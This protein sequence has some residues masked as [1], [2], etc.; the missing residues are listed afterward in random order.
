MFCNSILNTARRAVIHQTSGSTKPGISRRILGSQRQCVTSNS[1]RGST[2]YCRRGFQSRSPHWLFQEI[3]YRERYADLHDDAFE[4]ADAANGYDHFLRHGSREGRLGHLLFDPALYQSGL[5]ASERVNVDAIGPYQH[6]LRQIGNGRPETATTCYF[7]PAWYRKQYPDVDQAIGAGVWLSALHHYLCNGTPTEFDPL[8][9]FS[10]T[11]YLQRYKDVAEAVAAG[12]H[13][14]GYEHFLTHGITERRSPC[15]SID[16]RHYVTTHPGVRSDLEKRLAPDAFAHYLRIGRERGLSTTPPPEHQVTEAQAVTL[17]QRRADAQLL[18]AARTVLD[19]SVAGTP[20]VSAVLLLRNSFP[21]TLMAL[22]SLRAGYDGAIELVLVDAGSTDET[23][24]IGD[25]VRGAT[26]L[27]FERDLEFVPAANAALDC[28]SA[29]AV[30]LMDSAV[31]V[32]PGALSVALRRLGTDSRIGAVGGK[33]LRADG[34]LESAGGIVW[35]NGTARSYLRDGSPSAPEANFVRNV[36]FCSTAFLLLR[37]DLLNRIGGFNEAF[38][39]CGSAEVDLGL[40]LA[41]VDARVVYDPAVVAA[42]LTQ[43][44]PDNTTDEARQALIREHKEQLMRR[45]P[46][47]GKE[48]LFARANDTA[49]RVLFL[50]DTVPLRQL[51]SGF[52]RSND[53]IRVMVALGYGVTVYPINPC[54]LGLAA[55]YADMPNTV[56]VMHDQTIETL[57]NFLAARQDYYDVIWIA[58]T[59]NLDRVK[60]VAERFVTGRRPLV[61]LDTEAIAA[62]RDAG[63]AMLANANPAEVG[64]AIR[65]EFA[66]AAFCQRVVAVSPLEAEKLSEAGIPDVAVIGHWRDPRPTPRAFSD[67][68]GMLFFGAIHQPESPNRDALEWFALEVLPLVEQSLGWETRLT[69]AGYIAPG[70]SLQAYRDHPRITLRGMVDDV[71]P[72][73]DM[74]RLCVA[75]TRFAAGVPYKV[76]EAASYGLPLVASELLAG[77]LGWS[78][79]CE[80]LAADTANPAE[81]ARKIIT[82]YRDAALWQRLRDTALERVRAEHG[83][84][85]YKAAVRQILKS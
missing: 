8:P 61:V 29:S 9:E 85:Q 32:M 21:L 23:R 56:E 68:A 52:V 26:V 31:E 40:R 4:R 67:R 53:L 70:I 66:N 50:D 73:Y 18:M 48:E 17:N 75:P 57:T 46:Q 12:V 42:R 72:L 11:F 15:A 35:R 20:A 39:A 28:I 83:R 22:R 24:Q 2:R 44:A 34:R 69:V 76:H 41:E 79:D 59:H 27:R 45:R 49:R 33:L 25:F 10:E 7:D 51:G 80:L 71:A 62:L 63:R 14:N 6:Y 37:A 81:F 84:T 16:L 60:P 74:H 47:A 54:P 38:V 55:I 78:D 13:R 3:A 30:L 82:L 65:H 43:A 36:D 19:F 64:T 58:R 1:S 5:E 77:Q